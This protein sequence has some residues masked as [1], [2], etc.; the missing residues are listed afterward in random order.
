VIDRQGGQGTGGSPRMAPRDLFIS[1]SSA[2]TAAAREMRR[3]LEAA[4]YSCWMAPDDVRGMDPWA[5]QILEAIEGCRVMIV[6]LSASANASRH[7]SR[8][9][10]LALGKGKAILPVRIEEVPPEGALEYLLSLVQRVDAFPPPFRTHLEQIQAHLAAVLAEPGHAGATVLAGS[11]TGRDARRSGR[12]RGGL[13]SRLLA[14]LGGAAV[15]LVVLLVLAL[16][17][18]GT[19][20]AGGTASP[21]PTDGSA[22][23]PQASPT[24]VAA[25][26]RGTG[27]AEQPIRSFDDL[28][29]AIIALLA[30]SGGPAEYDSYVRRTDNSGQLESEFPDLWIDV[31]GITFVDQANAPIG[32]LL[33]ASTDLS[34]I[35]Q[36]FD[37]AGIFIGASTDRAAG[38]DAAAFLESLRPPFVQNCLLAGR[39]AVELTQPDGARLAGRL[40]VWQRC[41]GQP[42]VILQA[43]LLR[44]DGMVAFMIDARARSVADAAA[45]AHAL[46]RL[47]VVTPFIVTPGSTPG[48]P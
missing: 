24:A 3:H 39:H 17:P 18:G 9:V 32:V 34:R 27:I 37:T 40:V 4:G 21:T 5:E 2:D 25:T 10:N 11:R 45:I 26:P 13:D 48:M 47:R 29:A 31:S 22:A 8:E 33:A 7:V 20:G 6:L 30:D 35:Y 38:F 46:E 43:G 12:R 1:Y 23:T 14:G 36:A 16:L 15:G 41:Q 44:D 28:E 42:T 19:P